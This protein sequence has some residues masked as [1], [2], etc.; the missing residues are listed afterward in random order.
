MHEKDSG[1][2]GVLTCART[3][4]RANL[5]FGYVSKKAKSRTREVVGALHAVWE[6][7][8][9]V[10][11]QGF[12]AQRDTQT[13]GSQNQMIQEIMKQRRLFALERLV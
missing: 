5:V 4:P 11:P 12:P 7:V 6:V 10:C 2:Q 8:G 9:S 1:V 3:I 13:G